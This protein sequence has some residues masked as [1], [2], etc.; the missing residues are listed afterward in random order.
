MSEE[1]VKAEIEEILADKA[2]SDQD[3]ISRLAKMREDVRAEM[4]AATES[5]MV[6]DYDIGPELK[7]LDEALE[8]LGYTP[9]S[10]EDG[11]GATL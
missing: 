5:S 7:D 2:L 10:P 8:S 11:G 4:R 6:V 3:K 1:T 9:N